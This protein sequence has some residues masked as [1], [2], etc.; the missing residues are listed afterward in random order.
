M[1]T[2]AYGTWL[3]APSAF[4]KRSAA[5][6]IVSESR[7]KEREFQWKG[8]RTG[9]LRNLSLVAPLGLM[10]LCATVGTLAYSRVSLQAVSGAGGDGMGT[11]QSGELISA[12][13]KAASKPSTPPSMVRPHSCTHT[14]APT[15][16]HTHTPP[17][18]A[19]LPHPPLWLSSRRMR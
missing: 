11:L 1:A 4:A 6:P 16:T 7:R 2:G 14:D 18:H 3:N 12:H 8:E 10:V 9:Y 17:A 19:Y 13:Q 5:D 15:H